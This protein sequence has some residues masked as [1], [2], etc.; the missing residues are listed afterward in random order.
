MATFVLAILSLLVGV[1]VQRKLAARRQRLSIVQP[2]EESTARNVNF[3]TS[4]RS[5]APVQQMPSDF[6]PYEAGS[7]ARYEAGPGVRYE[8]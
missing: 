2:P 1:F 8:V 6:R 3:E 7:T 5:Q 4:E